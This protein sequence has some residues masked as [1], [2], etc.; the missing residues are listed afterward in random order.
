MR[1]PTRFGARSGWWPAAT[2]DG[3]SALR[4]LF[5]ALGPGLGIDTTPPPEPQPARPAAGP[6]GGPS[7]THRTPA[8]PAC[9]HRCT[10]RPPEREVLCLIG[11]G[12]TNAEIVHCAGLIPFS[13]GVLRRLRRTVG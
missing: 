1:C 4:R 6:P 2:R 13:G 11:E 9:T 10:H 8:G 7:D 5:T 3:P 12:R